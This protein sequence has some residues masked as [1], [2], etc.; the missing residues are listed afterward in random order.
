[1]PRRARRS[2]DSDA[3]DRWEL[4]V[5]QVVAYNLR[6]ARQLQK[7]TQATLALHLTAVSGLRFTPAMVSELER[8]WD[9]ERRRE[10]DAHEIAV[11]A[12]ALKVPIAYFFLPPPDEHRNLE[13]MGRSARELHLLFFGYFDT[14]EILDERMRKFGGDFPP[15][16]EEAIANLP[17]GVGPWTYKERRKELIMALLDGMADELDEALDKIGEF[18]DRA[19]Q[20]GIRGYIAARANDADFLGQAESRPS[21]SY[22]EE[23]PAD[24]PTSEAQD[25]PSADTAGASPEPVS[26]RQDSR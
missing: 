11:F 23:E 3:N 22:E 9:G 8:S 6:A 10:F 4:N 12:V 7:M 1:M 15:E 20:A 13:G 14:V 5:N 18:A 16:Y 24:S 21:I 2:R 17:S 25:D 19:R 26:T